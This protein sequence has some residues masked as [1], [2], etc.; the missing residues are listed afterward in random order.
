M[1]RTRLVQL[2]LLWLVVSAMVWLTTIW[3]WQGQGTDV[4]SAD[5]V[6]QLVLLPLALAAV[7]ATSIWLVG[8]T[9]REAAAPL[10]PPARP[11]ASFSQATDAA[12]PAD[13]QEETLPWASA[14]VLSE[15]VNLCMGPDPAQALAA[16]HT[17]AVRPGLDP[18][19]QDVDGMPVFAARHPELDAAAWAAQAPA[20]APWLPEAERALALLAPVL[21]DALAAL[22]DQAGPES[23]GWVAW[24]QRC[25]QAARVAAS[26]VTSQAGQPTYLA[27]VARPEPPSAQL[28]RKAQAPLLHIRLVLPPSWPAGQREQAVVWVKAQCGALLD[29]SEAM[30]ARGVNW[31]VEP[32]VQNEDLWAEVDQTL[33]RWHREGRPELLLMLAADTAITPHVVERMQARG[34]LFTAHHQVGR[35][36][37]EAAVALLLGTAHWLGQPVGAPV[38]HAADPDQA[39]D[40]AEASAVRL[41]RPL[42]SR[43]DKSADAHGRLGVQAL[44]GALSQVQAQ[45]RPQAD[46]LRV[47]ADADHRASRTS[48]LYE[49]VA[50]VS[51]EVD[52]MLAI[53][54]V[55]Q[56]C[57]DLGVAGALVPSALASAWL[58]AGDAAAAPAAAPDAQPL[59]LAVLLQSSHERV[60]V[61]LA[62]WSRVLKAA[63]PQAQTAA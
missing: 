40:A 9:R 27:G 45:H 26:Q 42:R 54:R 56:A 33:V 53:A 29:W 5:L 24:Q 38:P 63:E 39:Q 43:R 57:G 61:P 4:G 21:Q 58:R 32:L 36:P 11:A 19:L 6:L 35:M 59:A 12:P 3:R 55:G 50:A 52:P 16:A 46:A 44:A 18:E 2:A 47:V 13:V 30:S 15:H 37:G 14:V 31:L 10:T 8:R 62:P 48:E 41:W 51:P 60:V 7:L 28:A 17:G 20:A 22:T 23:P 25:G 49:A 34:E 1:T